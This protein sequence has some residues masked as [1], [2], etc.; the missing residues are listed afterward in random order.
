MGVMC[1]KC[2]RK[3]R[4]G[5]FCQE[6]GGKVKAVARPPKI[7]GTVAVYKYAE[8]W[9]ELREEEG[10]NFTERLT[11]EEWNSVYRNACATLQIEVD[12]HTHEA[13]VIGLA[14]P[15]GTDDG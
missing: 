3:Q 11:P 13:T 7:S 9:D 1:E 6:C 14:L 12:T 8:G 15:Q 4:G 2:G 5:K 10:R